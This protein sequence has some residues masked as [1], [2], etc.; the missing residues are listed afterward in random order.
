M[1]NEKR[2]SKRA[3]AAL[4]KIGIKKSLE[5]M[6]VPEDSE[7][8]FTH[9]KPDDVKYFDAVK[10]EKNSRPNGFYKSGS[11][12]HFDRKFNGHP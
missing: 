12:Y 3:A 5:N 4:A 9:V 8:A 10:K 6:E 1:V 11:G 2:R 7:R